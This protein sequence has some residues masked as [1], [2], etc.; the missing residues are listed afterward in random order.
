MSN[1]DLAPGL[2]LDADYIGGGTVALLAKKNAGKTYAG[3]VMAEEFWR[4]GVPFVALDPMDAWWGLRSSADGTG[5]GIGVAIFGGPHGDAPLERTGGKVLADLVVDE[6]LSM[7]LNLKE[8]GSRAAERQFA[9]DFLERLYRRNSELVH[10]L[11]DEADLF[12]PQQPQAGDQP[13]LGITE[14]I[15]RRGR[16]S[17]IGVTLI[18]QRPAVLNK[19]VLTQV[20]AL[21]AM[22]MLGPNDRDAIDR[23]VGV[24]G[25]TEDARPIKDT[26]PNLETGQ[27]WWWVPELGVLKLVKIRESHT[28]DSSPTRKRGQ[29]RAEPKSFADVD[30]SAIEAKMADTIERQKADNPKELRRRIAELEEQVKHPLVESI[31]TYVD[32]V[33][34][35]VP[36]RL[37]E[38]AGRLERL[39][40]EASAMAEQVYAID[41][42]ETPMSE[43]AGRVPEVITPPRA[44]EQ[45]LSPSGTW[46]GTHLDKGP[47]RILAALA[48]RHPMRTTRA[49]LGTLSGYTARGGTFKKYFGILVRR[50]MLE[51]SGGDVGVTALGL[52]YVGH[53]EVPASSPEET[54]E[55]WRNALEG[56]PRRLF[57]VLVER[58]PEWETKE[59]LGELTGYTAEGGTFKKYL[60][61]LARNDLIDKDDGQVCLSSS[62][63]E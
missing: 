21:V 28:F 50:G 1:L 46:D 32:V 14:N 58:F 49:Q 53:Q 2:K 33:P 23:W 10:L 16:N 40:V 4:A 29:V 8:L 5:E 55:M 6:R 47:T 48:Q 9:M 25:D 62:L 61:I 18:T 27:A 59:R 38:V 26:L 30:M 54:R 41:L 31:V 39:S 45:V 51:D 37:T 24:H 12:A 43:D 7:V 60:G 52:E 34:S 44:H 17:G 22:R 11:I 3:R 19:D 63:F 42:P 56:G 15:V 57:D 35:H 13:L 36:D 20:D